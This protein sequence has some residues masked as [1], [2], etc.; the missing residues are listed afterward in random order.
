MHR[1]LTEQ[2]HTLAKAKHIHLQTSGGLAAAAN[3]GQ[4]ADTPASLAVALSASEDRDPVLDKLLTAASTLPATLP[5]AFVDALAPPLKQA[6][7]EAS[8]Q[9]SRALLRGVK[10]ARQP[11]HTQR[12]TPS[13]F[14][15][16]LKAQLPKLL[17]ESPEMSE[18][19]AA[20]V[21]GEQW[22]D[23]PPAARAPFLAQYA[24]AQ[25]NKAAPS[26]AKKPRPSTGA[27]DQ[28][29]GQS[30]PAP[31]P[32]TSSVPQDSAV[33]PAAVPDPAGTPQLQ[34]AGESST[35]S[36][37]GLAS[38]TEETKVSEALAPTPGAR[39]SA[40]PPASPETTAGPV[41]AEPPTSTTAGPA[42]DSTTTK[43]SSES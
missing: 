7:L 26:P 17:E 33:A 18:V 41:Q 2:L 22:R 12:G 34:P 1:L 10:R 4:A 6:L 19:E 29:H 27:T 3:A 14:L 16:Y 39:S 8:A 11:T 30:D 42:P 36:H 37:E 40:A 21:A 38:T 24:K 25:P 23:M 32:A 35:A 9:P 13:P 15:F 5:D 20:V 28:E 31:T 43:Q